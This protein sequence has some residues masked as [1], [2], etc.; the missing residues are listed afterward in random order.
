MK[1]IDL[2]DSHEVK[3]IAPG[4]GLNTKEKRKENVETAL[5]FQARTTRW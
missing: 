5:K 2:K 3:W 4:Y 1:K